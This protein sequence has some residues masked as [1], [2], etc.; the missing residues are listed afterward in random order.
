M[1]VYVRI[2]LYIYCITFA[3][4]HEGY[5]G[6]Y[7]GTKYLEVPLNDMVPSTSVEYQL[8]ILGQGITHVPS[9]VGT[10]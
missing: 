3:Y 6:A 5:I 7:S 2:C 10:L 1:C 4:Q 8:H 9:V